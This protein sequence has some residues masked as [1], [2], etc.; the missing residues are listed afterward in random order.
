MDRIYQRT[1]RSAVIGWR[2][3]GPTDKR[4][5]T[6]IVQRRVGEE[7]WL[8]EQIAHRVTPGKRL[9]TKSHLARRRSSSEAVAPQ[10]K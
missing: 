6:P 5:G 10:K 2:I 8:R 7:I 4:P 9:L 3:R 1:G